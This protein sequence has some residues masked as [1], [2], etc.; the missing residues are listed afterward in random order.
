MASLPEEAELLNCLILSICKEFQICSMGV[1]FHTRLPFIKK[2][3][4]L[5]YAD[6][7]S[8]VYAYAVH[9]WYIHYRVLSMFSH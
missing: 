8:T 3:C 6:V 7:Y 5:Q 2:I 9:C 4:V 1:L